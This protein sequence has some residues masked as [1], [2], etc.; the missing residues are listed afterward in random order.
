MSLWRG[1]N[2]EFLHFVGR[3]KTTS[4]HEA[5]CNSDAMA[6]P[7]LPP[8]VSHSLV[9]A[10]SC[11]HYWSIIWPYWASGSI[12]RNEEVF[13]GIPNPILARSALIAKAVRC[14]EAIIELLTSIYPLLLMTMDWEAFHISL[15]QWSSLLSSNSLRIGASRVRYSVSLFDDAWGWEWI[16]SLKMYMVE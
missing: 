1:R 8:H 15:G 11:I 5:Q 3:P 14:R 7:L 6:V 9:A 2:L 13:F 16:V 4:Q 10:R 12:C